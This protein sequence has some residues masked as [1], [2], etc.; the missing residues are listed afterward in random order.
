MEELVHGALKP[1]IIRIIPTWLS[2]EIKRTREFTERSEFL[3]Q[4]ELYILLTKEERDNW[5]ETLHVEPLF[6]ELLSQL[7]ERDSSIPE[8]KIR[9]LREDVIYG[10]QKGKRLRDLV[11]SGMECGCQNCHFSH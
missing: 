9:V 3:L 10:E 7:K 4:K 1:N 11:Q 5:N 6:D 2:E 8:E